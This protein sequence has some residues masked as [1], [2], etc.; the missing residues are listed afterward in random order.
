MTA[1]EGGSDKLRTADRRTALGREP[2]VQAMG[3]NIGFEAARSAEG[4]NFWDDPK[5]LDVSPQGLTDQLTKRAA[6]TVVLALSLGLWAAI[7][8]AVA[9]L[10]SAMFG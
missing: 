6:L 1:G 7:W 5:Q 3:T 8:T 9:S 4:R 2:K 10:A